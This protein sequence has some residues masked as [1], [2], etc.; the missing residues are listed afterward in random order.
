MQRSVVLG[1][2]PLVLTALA[3]CLPALEDFRVVEGPAPIRDGGSRDG[4]QSTLDGATTPPRTMAEPPLGTPCRDV[5]LAA[6]ASS[7]TSSTDES[8]IRRFQLPSG[9]PCL[10]EPLGRRPGELRE[11]VGA[12][13]SIGG[14]LRVGVRDTVVAIGEDGFAR[15]RQRLETERGTSFFAAELFTTPAAPPGT[16]FAAVVERDDDIDGIVVLGDQ[17]EVLTRVE[18]GLPFGLKTLTYDPFAA[19]EGRWLLGF[20]RT[21]ESVVFSPADGVFTDRREFESPRPDSSLVS[22]V[23][24]RTRGGPAVALAFEDAVVVAQSWTWDPPPTVMA[25]PSTCDSFLVAVPDPFSEGA[26]AICVAEVRHLVALP[27]CEIIDDGTFIRP[28]LLR[29]LT[30]VTRAA[31]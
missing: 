1:S 7:T 5:F 6:T 23:A 14:E 18:R 26:Y 9:T 2:L 29:G 21:L 15:W 10:E 17:G 30:V 25:C 20:W 19:E 27:G 16:L 13:G 31:E 28:R 12:L 22:A 11:A 3:G 24:G 8:E 4:G